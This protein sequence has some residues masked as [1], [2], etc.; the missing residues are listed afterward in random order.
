MVASAADEVSS[1]SPRISPQPVKLSIK[2]GEEKL[3][4]V[5]GMDLD[6][7]SAT[8][9]VLRYDPRTIDVSQVAFGP[10]VSIDPK[11]P[12]VVKIDATAGTV[13]ITS[14]D[15]KP[16]SFASGGEIAT[17]RVRGGMPGETYL[18]LDNPSFKNGRGE[19]VASAVSGGRAKVE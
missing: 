2:P 19:G 7:L 13:T 9:V 12:P 8:Q 15:G 4:N 1:L 17:L 10:A 3:W 11:T 5:V 18:V 6:G 14:S 16:L